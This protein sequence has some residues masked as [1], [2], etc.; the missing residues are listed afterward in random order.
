MLCTMFFS[1]GLTDL[2]FLMFRM[3]FWGKVR[4]MTQV[5]LN[6]SHPGYCDIMIDKNA[7]IWSFRWPKNI[8]ISH[9]WSALVPGWRA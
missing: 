5:V 3:E 7:H 2:F 4:K 6:S 9:I 8:G 1:M